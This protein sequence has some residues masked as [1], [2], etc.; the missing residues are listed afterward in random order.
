MEYIFVNGH[1]LRNGKFSSA[2]LYPPHLF[3][4][5]FLSRRGAPLDQGLVF[6]FGTV[7]TLSIVET[8]C[9][10]GPIIRETTPCS[11]P[12]GDWVSVIPRCTLCGTGE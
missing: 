9:Q 2:E 10:D 1:D 4:L 3:R 11:D 5:L 8:K 6:I 7:A 12:W